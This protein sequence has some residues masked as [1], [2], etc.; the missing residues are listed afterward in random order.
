MRVLA[1]IPARY[2]STRFPGKPLLP[3]GGRPMVQHVY[4]RLTAMPAISTT[5]VAT[6]DQRI[7]EAVEQFGGR[8]MLTAQTHRSGTDRCGEVL[9]KLDAQGDSYDLVL[10]VQGDEPFVDTTQIETLVAAFDDPA[11]QIATLRKRIDNL[12][13]LGSPNAVK[14][15]TDLNGN[16]LYFSRH[17]IPYCRDVQPEALLNHAAYYKHIGLYAFRSA[18]LRQLVE[19]QPTP[20]EKAENLE[21][22]R[23]IENGYTIKVGLT[24]VE[25]LSVDTPDDYKK[26]IKHC[27]Q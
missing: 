2:A 19:L 1:I 14:V 3:I 4:D 18:V 15:V 7:V 23:W 16:A 11:T 6:E 20:L 24:E 12:E 5:I 21:Q 9:R 25:N 13:L 27:A 8:V 26:L 10:N 22:L 17:A